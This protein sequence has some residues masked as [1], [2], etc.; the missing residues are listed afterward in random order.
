MF[1]V[2]APRNYTEGD[3][4][5]R[6]NTYATLIQDLN[7][8]GVKSELTILLIRETQMYV[9]VRVCMTCVCV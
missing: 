3:H 5:F 6:T 7:N 4:L 9:C 2:H 8:K 1:S